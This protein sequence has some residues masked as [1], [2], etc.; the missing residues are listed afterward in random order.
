MMRRSLAALVRDRAAVAAVD[1]AIVAVP[2]LM[3]LLGTIEFGRLLWT[4]EAIQMTAVN[5]A[6]CMGVLA[7]SCTMSGA[8]NATSA[9]SYIEGVAGSWGITLTASNLTLTPTAAA[10]ACTG[11]S[12]VSISYTFQTVIPGLLT[13]LSG[14]QTL[15]GH[16]CFPKQS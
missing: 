5:G 9:S 12:E 10:G 6:R 7:S 1:F 11:L 4:R 13:M 2:M 3:L 16:A 8:Y 14:G 15:T